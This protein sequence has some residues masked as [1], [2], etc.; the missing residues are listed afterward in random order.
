MFLLSYSPAIVV[1]LPFSPSKAPRLSTILIIPP[2]PSGSY[3]A[4]GLV[5]TSTLS[6]IATCIL[7]TIPRL[8]EPVS[9][10]R[11]PSIRIV[12]FA[13]PAM[14]TS[15]SI[16]TSKVGTFLSRSNPVPPA[17]VRFFPTLK[18]CLSTVCMN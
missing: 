3:F 14:D 9:P 15:P 6:T 1:I 7:S 11:L 13:S 2:T 5:I 8:F 10:D 4:D 12:T 16:L 17:A 18:I